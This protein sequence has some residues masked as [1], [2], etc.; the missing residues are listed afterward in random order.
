MGCKRITSSILLTIQNN[1]V[2][3]LQ[4]FAILYLKKM[5][6]IPFDNRNSI[7]LKNF[8]RSKLWSP[9]YVKIFANDEYCN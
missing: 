6:K 4:S 9:F 8:R 3:N 5:K 1:F 7:K 2:H